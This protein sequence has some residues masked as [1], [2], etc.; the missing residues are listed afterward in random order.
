MHKWRSLTRSPARP[1]Y[2]VVVVGRK[3]SCIR[4]EK[5]AFEAESIFNE[6]GLPAC[7]REQMKRFLSLLLLLSLRWRSHWKWKRTKTRRLFTATKTAATTKRR[8]KNESIKTRRRYQLTERRQGE[9]VSGSS[10]SWSVDRYWARRKFFPFFCNIYYY[11]PKWNESSRRIVNESDS[12]DCLGERTDWDELGSSPHAST[13][14]NCHCH[15]LLLRL[16]RP[17]PQFTWQ[18]RGGTIV[19]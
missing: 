9:M 1:L 17:Q 3:G 11:F 16:S 4:D 10:S 18:P 12:R 2:W 19:H 6:I 5:R 8:R 14:K 15:R 7:L 13:P